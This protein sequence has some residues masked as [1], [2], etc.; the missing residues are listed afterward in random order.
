MLLSD[1]KNLVTYKNSIKT[2]YIAL[3][4]TTAG[5]KI[6]AYYDSTLLQKFAHELK[7]INAKIRMCSG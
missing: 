1:N 2:T 7:H 4:F 3:G 6:A 5:Q